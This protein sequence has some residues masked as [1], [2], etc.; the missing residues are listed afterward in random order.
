MNLV[1]GGGCLINN[2]LPG[3]SL[4]VLVENRMY[5]WINFG[6]LAKNIFHVMYCAKP[7]VHSA[8]GASMYVFGGSGTV[9]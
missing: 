8:S 2:E 1:G 9:G 3:N 5:I 7:C 6:G 4:Y